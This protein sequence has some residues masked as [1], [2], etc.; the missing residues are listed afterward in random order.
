MTTGSLPERS[1]DGPLASH[2]LQTSPLPGGSGGLPAGSVEEAT[3]KLPSTLCV[4][5]ETFEDLVL[6]RPQGELDVSTSPAFRE[7]VRRYDPA[8]VQLVVDLAEVRLLDSAG[9]GEL[10]GLRNDVR[11][12]GGRLGLVCPQH[13]LSRLFWATGVRPAFTFGESLAAVRAALAESRSD[14]IGARDAGPR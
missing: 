8:E 10:V 14:P 3:G 2:A 4:V 5:S 7:H 1:R 6:V 9:L 12:S 11:R 13:D